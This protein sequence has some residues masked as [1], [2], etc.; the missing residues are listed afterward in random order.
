M[1]IGAIW[2]NRLVLL[3]VRLLYAGL[4]LPDCTFP[5]PR[6]LMRRLTCRGFPEVSVKSGQRSGPK[7]RPQPVQALTGDIPGIPPGWS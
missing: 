1:G 2:T 7:K 3:G 5:I 4:K 6:G